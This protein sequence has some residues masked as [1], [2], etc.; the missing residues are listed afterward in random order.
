MNRREFLRSGDIVIC[1]RSGIVGWGARL[2]RW[3]FGHHAGLL[4]VAETARGR[5][6][7]ILEAVFPWVR[8]RALREDDWERIHVY[9]VIGATLEDGKKAWQA[10]LLYVGQLYGWPKAARLIVR[11]AF[12]VL[13]RW[14]PAYVLV[15]TAP[16]FCS[17]L[18]TLCWR[19][20]PGKDPVPGMKAEDVA[21]QHL[22][23]S[24]ATWRVY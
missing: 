17:E 4:R 2:L 12:W 14:R 16:V 10:G 3:P 23:E 24:E 5:V 22:A 18:C 9:R 19:E 13:R 7:Y 8:L 1:A 11:R 6:Y 20:G 21:P 15:A